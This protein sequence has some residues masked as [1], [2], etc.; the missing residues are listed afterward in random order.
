MKILIINTAENKG[1]AAVACNRLHEALVSN[2]YDSKMLVRQKSNAD[3][4]VF[5]F[6]NSPFRKKINLFFFFIELFILKFFKKKE[7]D[8]SLPWFGP[9]LHKHSLVKDA[10]IIHLHWVQNSF[11]SMRCLKKLQEL[12]KPIIWTLHDMWAFTGGCHYNNDCRKFETSC[13][14]CP[15]LKN[16]SIADFSRSTFKSKRE[17][18]TSKLNI[19]TP[20]KWLAEEVKI[21]SLLKSNPIQVI[22]YN[23]NFDVFG[24]MNKVEAKKQF[25]ISAEKKIILFVSMNIEDQRKGFEY[26][27]QAILELENTVPN[28][29]DTHEILAIGRNSDIKH[30]NTTIHYTGRLSDVKLIS[31]AYSAADV[32]VAPSKQDNLP[33]TVI[34]SMACGTPVVAFNIGGM[35]DMIKHQETGYLANPFNIVELGNGITYCL[36]N[37]LTE[38]S[39]EWALSK[40][41]GSE[42]VKS[43]VNLYTELLNV[44]K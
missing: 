4:H 17:I 42:I 6:T 18:F 24:Q 15:Q 39:R 34:E 3:S 21:S 37:N 16:T 25:G 41:Q 5:E 43:Y 33:N 44:K 19:V 28:W 38:K 11:V 12:N 30:F 13:E 14:Q 20:S 22:P 10:D 31:M 32:F 23:I 29:T 27:K 40:F 8:F 2:G 35:P 26:F 36:R 9:A 1:G 7:F